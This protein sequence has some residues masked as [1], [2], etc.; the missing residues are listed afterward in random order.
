VLVDF[1]ELGPHPH[2]SK[3]RRQQPEALPRK[4]EVLLALT[5]LFFE[6]EQT[7]Q[8]DQ[9]EQHAARELRQRFVNVVDLLY[10]V[11]KVLVNLEPGL[12]FWTQCASFRKCS[13]CKPLDLPTIMYSRDQLYFVRKR[14][15]NFETVFIAA[16]RK[17]FK[18]EM[19]KDLVM[20]RT[21][22][23]I[24]SLEVV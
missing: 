1:K 22:C 13:Q 2:V 24:C 7:V 8:V 17:N 3:Q 18:V 14:E 20:F 9:R 16:A 6:Q 11:R 5:T 23:L 15:A 4:V 10:L 19:P 12:P 21:V